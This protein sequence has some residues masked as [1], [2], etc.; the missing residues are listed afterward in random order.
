MSSA[1]FVVM[2]VESHGRLIPIAIL[3]L[4][5]QADRLRVKYRRDLTANGDEIDSE[6]LE[7]LLAELEAAAAERSGSEILLDYE[8]TLS[9]SV[10]ITDRRPVDL[11]VPIDDLLARLFAE[12]V[13]PLE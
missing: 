2:Q 3:L 7:P 4:D 10:R 5:C 13:A 9:N 1:Q 12:H 11:D 8:D 6:I